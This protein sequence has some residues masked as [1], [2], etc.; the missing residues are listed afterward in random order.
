MGT[1]VIVLVGVIFVGFGVLVMFL[2]LRTFTVNDVTRRL[3]DFVSVQSTELTAAPQ[4]TSIRRT[5]L[6]GS[7]RTRMLE[8]FIRQ[9]GGFFGRD[10]RR[11][12]VDPFGNQVLELLLARR[13]PRSSGPARA[14]RVDRCGGHDDWRGC[15]RWSGPELLSQQKEPGTQEQEV[16]QRV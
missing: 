4:Q 5:D 3:N 13:V 7:F 8:P 16:Q 11:Q 6:T 1:L 10:A 15:R 2:G 12:H 9:I 14:Q